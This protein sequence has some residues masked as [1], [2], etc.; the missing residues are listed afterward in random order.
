MNKPL[1]TSL[2]LFALLGASP[3]ARAEPAAFDS[4]EAAV[5]A[6]LSALEASDRTALLS[7]FGP[8]FEDLVFTGDPEKDREIWGGFLRDVTTQ[9]RIDVVDGDRAVLYAGREQWAFPAELIRSGGT[10]RFDS[11]GARDEVRF[12]RIGLNEL[13]VIDLMRRAAPAQARFRAVDHDGDGVMEFASSILSSPG[14]RDGLYW[15]D[16]PGTEQSPIGAYLARANSDGFALD[17]TES[18]PDP[19]LGYYFRILQ[20]Q[21]P[22]APGGAYDYMVNGNMVAGHALLAYPAA[23]GETGVMSFIVGEAGT[24]YQA[25]LGPETLAVAGAIDRFDPGADWT[26][27]ED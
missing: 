3:A 14:T 6:L 16:E 11:E 23:P 22:A 12:R 15:P 26:P 17:G 5:E 13:D 7:V 27:V 18:E 4:P 9:R 21:G 24:V 19:Y 10:W 2:A 1:L 8:E 25:D 20:G